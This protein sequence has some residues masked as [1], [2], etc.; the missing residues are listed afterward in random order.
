LVAT[1]A[2]A[3]PCLGVLLVVVLMGQWVCSLSDCLLM[4]QAS[5]GWQQQPHKRCPWCGSSMVPAAQA[6]CCCLQLGAGRGSSADAAAAAAAAAEAC[7]Q[8][9]AAAAIM[10]RLQQVAA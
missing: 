6:A 3:W 5:A 10:L 9:A 2:S 4:Q 7:A 1:A 8:A